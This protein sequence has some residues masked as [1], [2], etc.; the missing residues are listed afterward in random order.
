M[1]LTYPLVLWIGICVLAAV[2][3]LLHVIRIRTEYRGGKRAANT[4]FARKLPRYRRRKMLDRMLTVIAEAGLI[5]AILLSL[6]LTARPYRTE[7]VSEG[8]KKRDIFL[9]MDISYS[10]CDLNYDLV[11]SLKQVV[12]NLNGDRFGISIYNTSTV[13]Y[14]PMTD[15]YDFVLDRLDKLHDYFG[16]QKQYMDTFGNYTYVPFGDEE[17][18][19]ELQK[20]LDDFEAGTL[21]N[22]T[23]KGSSL[24]G[25]G[26]AS[27]LYNF[28]RLEEEDRTRIILMS[29][30]NSQEALSKPLVDLDGA[31]ELCEKYGVKI[32]GIFP[33]RSAFSWSN[34]HDYDSSFQ[35]FQADVQKTG[36]TVYQKTEFMSVDDIV[37]QIQEQEAKEISTLVVTQRVDQ[38]KGFVIGLLVSVMIFLV[39]E[40]VRL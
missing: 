22:N 8:E 28:P 21:V 16:L 6:I 26:L 38:P 23:R 20:K 29:T 18:Y 34:S 33:D 12:S 3:I 15:D 37:R 10:L 17:E 32:F 40:A 1:E 2:V 30:D 7:S 9:C 14:V 13:L 36:G 5:S 35:Q 4:A 31:V 11:E 25:E 27:C 24:V 39:G 19:E